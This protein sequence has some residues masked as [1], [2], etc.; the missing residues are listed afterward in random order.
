MSENEMDWADA[1]ERAVR[2]VIE[3]VDEDKSSS[4]FT[5]EHIEIAVAELENLIPR[6]GPVSTWLISAAIQVMIKQNESDHEGLT[7]NTRKFTE[8]FEL[9]S[10]SLV[11]VDKDGSIELNGEDVPDDVKEF[12]AGL[13]EDLK[14]RQDLSQEELAEF[15]DKVEK[16]RSKYEEHPLYQKLMGENEDN[17]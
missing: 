13:V 10:V 7:Y 2:T 12:L 15:K 8:H 11:S 4:D 1:L 17:Q 9:D 16:Q 6:V 3:I 5:E 14:N